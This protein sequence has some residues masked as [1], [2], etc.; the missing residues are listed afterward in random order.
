M[1]PEEWIRASAP[2]PVGIV[3]DQ[4]PTVVAPGAGSHHDIGGCRG[5]A[6]GSFIYRVVRGDN[7]GVRDEGLE[8]CTLDTVSG[9]LVSED[10][11]VGGAPDPAA[12]A[13]RRVADHFA[14]QPNVDVLLEQ[15]AV[16]CPQ[17]ASTMGLPGRAGKYASAS[18]STSAAAGCSRLLFSLDFFSETMA[19]ASFLAAAGCQV[20]PTLP[21]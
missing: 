3:R 20:V 16:R 2:A 4:L 21:W 6:T 1:K 13:T 7:V 17:C 10:S 9:G 12:S 11:G 19:A 14:G 5:D 8:V 15:R 18:T